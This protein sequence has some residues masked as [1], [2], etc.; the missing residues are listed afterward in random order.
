MMIERD[1]IP[2]LVSNMLILKKIIAT[3]QYYS[4]KD[5]ICIYRGKLWNASRILKL[6]ASHR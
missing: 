4:L 1:D 3:G 5:E 2:L 6:L